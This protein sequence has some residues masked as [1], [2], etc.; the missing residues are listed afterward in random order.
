MSRC[1]PRIVRIFLQLK[2]Y[3][4]TIIWKPGKHMQVLDTLS[5]AYLP[6]TVPKKQ[7]E[8][9]IHELLKHLPISDEKYQEL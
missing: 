9:E 5:R 6:S 4:L 2:K 3:D 7:I 1:L 8:V